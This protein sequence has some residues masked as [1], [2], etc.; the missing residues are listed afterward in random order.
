ME[1]RGGPTMESQI[2]LIAASFFARAS[3]LVS[4]AGVAEHP[5]IN[6]KSRICR[7]DPLEKGG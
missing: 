4:E 7:I 6:K 1:S 2:S 5:A 3:A